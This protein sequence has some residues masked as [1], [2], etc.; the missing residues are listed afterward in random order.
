MVLDTS[1]YFNLEK[2]GK[3]IRKRREAL[4]LTQDELAFSAGIDASHI[5]RIEK[6]KKQPSLILMKNIFKALN[7]EVDLNE[8]E[9]LN[10]ETKKFLEEHVDYIETL[11][12]FK[13]DMKGFR[14]KYINSSGSRDSD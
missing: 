5:S 14:G 1:K 13:Q 2:P 11:K 3:Y 12:A 10:T 8:N 4:G 9:G 6:G 7:V